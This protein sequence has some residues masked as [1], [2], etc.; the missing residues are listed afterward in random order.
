MVREEFP[1][2]YC[3]RRRRYIVSHTA[4]SLLEAGHEIV[5]AGQSLPRRRKVSNGGEADG[6]ARAPHRVA[7]RRRKD[8][9]RMCLRNIHLRCEPFPPGLKAVGESV[10]KPLIL[11]EQRRTPPWRCAGDA[12][13][14]AA[15]CWYFSSSATVLAPTSYAAPGG[16]P[17]SLAPI[18]TLDQVVD[19]RYSPTW[20]LQIPPGLSCC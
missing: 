17:H 4:L 13:F 2:G 18:P 20:P 19:E 12:S 5:C 9:R 10:A 3:S 7:T 15:V 11:S 1:C 16:F 6:K 8:G 14:L